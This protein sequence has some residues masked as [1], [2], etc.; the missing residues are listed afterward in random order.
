MRK[1]KKSVNFFILQLVE[2]T[3]NAINYMPCSNFLQNDILDKHNVC[4]L[5][6]K[7]WH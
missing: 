4:K 5:L 6:K 2:T 1:A 7:M 3:A